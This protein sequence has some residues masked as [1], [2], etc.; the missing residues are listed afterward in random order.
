MTENE[1]DKAFEDM[2]LDHLYATYIE[3]NCGGDRFITD[4][5]LVE[6][7]EEG[8]L[9]DSFKESLVTVWNTK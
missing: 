4:D 3:E 8:Y 2:E 7:M 5:N 1:F 9:L 6:A